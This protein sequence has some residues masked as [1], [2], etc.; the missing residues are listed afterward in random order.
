MESLA[1][2][3]I[4]L[5]NFGSK[6]LGGI[7]KVAGWIAPTLHKVMADFIVFLSLFLLNPRLHSQDATAITNPQELP[8]V[9]FCGIN[10]ALYP[11][12]RKILD[13]LLLPNQIVELLAFVADL[14]ILKPSSQL[15]AVGFI[16]ILP[17]YVN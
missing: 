11:S 10:I 9:I 12:I 13:V 15:I 1:K 6:I 5:K 2:K 3:F 8:V 14:D 4:K 7:K 17:F 16:Y